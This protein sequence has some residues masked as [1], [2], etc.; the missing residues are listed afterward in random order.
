MVHRFVVSCRA[1]SRG[2]EFEMLYSVRKAIAEKAIYFAYKKTDRNNV[3]GGL[4]N[5]LTENVDG[6]FRLN[7][8]LLE[9]KRKEYKGV[10]SVH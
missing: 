1:F 9:K 10:L 2:V 6:E 4:M 7:E 3:V 5:L 8:K